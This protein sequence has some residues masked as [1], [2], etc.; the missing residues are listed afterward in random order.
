MKKHIVFVLV[1]ASLLLACT[2]TV[3]SEIPVGL[4]SFDVFIS[5]NGTPGINAF[6]IF[7][8]TGSNFGPAVGPPYAADPLTFDNAT[9]TVNSQ[10]G[11][12][13]INLGNI[14]PGELL[15]SSGNPIIQ[16]PSVENF[17]SALFTATLSSTNF[18]LSDGT[19]F[20]ASGS[21]SVDLLPSSG[22]SLQPGVDFAVINA[23]PAPVAMPESNTVVDLFVGTAAIGVFAIL[24]RKQRSRLTSG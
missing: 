10:S 13:V 3:A 1:A 16:F 18:A 19:T 12:S 11:S 8:F 22:S 6:D 4:L 7:N 20:T 5:A 9:L 24:T 2:F 15:D 21:I 17:T 14:G 23:E